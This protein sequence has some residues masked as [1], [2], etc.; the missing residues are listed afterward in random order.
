MNTQRCFLTTGR[1]ILLLLTFAAEALAQNAQ[2]TGLIT[3]SNSALIAGA[4]LTLTNVDNSLTRRAVT[5]RVGHYSI[6]FVPP[7]NYQLHVL[8]DGFKPMTRND[9]TINVDQAARID[10]TLE[11]GALTESVN[12]TRIDKTERLFTNIGRDKTVIIEA[13]YRSAVSDTLPD[14]ELFACEPRTQL[15][16]NGTMSR[17][18]NFARS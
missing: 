2:I 11:P 6:P 7:G 8:A 12:I 5:N 18:S 4:R 15:F 17:S 16:S 14:C 1:L 9:L 13:S 3:D 10:L